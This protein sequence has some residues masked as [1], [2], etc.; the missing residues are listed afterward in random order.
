M[1]K[2]R[3]NACG[4]VHRGEQPPKVCPLCVLDS[5]HFVEAISKRKQ[6]KQEQTKE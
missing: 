6:A 2:W 1:K 5:T 4:Y 3:C